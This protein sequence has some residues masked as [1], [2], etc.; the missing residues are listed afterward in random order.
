MERQ[1]KTEPF[2]ILMQTAK[3]I[4]DQIKMEISKS[5][6]NITEFSVFRNTVS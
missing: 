5:D 4:Q 3:N 6:L 2:K 1:C